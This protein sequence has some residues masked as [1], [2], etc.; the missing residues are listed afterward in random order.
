MPMSIIGMRSASPPAGWTKTF[1]AIQIWSRV[2][3]EMQ[4]GCYIDLC[5]CLQAGTFV[6]ECA[7]NVISFASSGR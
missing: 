7:E 5:L 1:H 3:E 4:E 2:R 6:K